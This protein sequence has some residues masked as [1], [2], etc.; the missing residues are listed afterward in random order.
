MDGADASLR[1]TVDRWS[2]SE[3]TLLEEHAD[4]RSLTVLTRWGEQ[5][6]GDLEPGT[7][8]ALRRMRFGPV[9][10]AGGPDPAGGPWPRAV[11]GDPL[12]GIL[13]GLRCAVVPTLTAV[14]DGRP[15]ASAIPEVADPQWSPARPDEG[16]LVRLSRFASLR[17]A[18][19][20]L[21]L[22]VPGAAYRVLLL[23][24]LCRTVAVSLT[25]G[26]TAAAVAERV[27]LPAPLVADLVAFLVGAGA[28]L[29]GDA[30]GFAEDEDPVRRGWSHHELL[31][32]HRSRHREGERPDDVVVDAAL[33]HPEPVTRERPRGRRF[34]LDRPA[35]LGE[36]VV[37]DTPLTALLETEQC[38]PCFTGGVLSAEKLGELLYRTARVRGRA[39]DDVRPSD[40]IG[41]ASSR[42]Y[43]NLACLY[44]L[45]VYVTVNRC[46]GLPRAIYHYDPADHALTQVV[47]DGSGVTTLLDAATEGTGSSLEPAALMTVTARMP[48]TSWLLG[49]SSYAMAL[50]HCGALAE[51]VHLA[52]QTMTM[53]VRLVP[54]L[55]GEAE[56]AL[57][58]PW[59][60]EVCVAHCAVE[61]LADAA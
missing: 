43:L 14:E 26:T 35:D 10:L 44:E 25:R 8:Q 7:A 37:S 36:L 45:E 41:N 3:D 52:A 58:L 19:G 46:P 38:D 42:P 27:G 5:V 9:T 13:D 32:H 15:L 2:F 39:T 51:T 50:V 4:P 30:S 61:A 28:L 21:V 12:P 57:Q 24:P 56:R 33:A 34:P 16:T 29:V 59:P 49:G 40:P 47:D 11:P 60:A 17:P 23:T 54:P 48:R 1:A 20:D 53:A 55:G 22:E 6:L 31:F 18:D